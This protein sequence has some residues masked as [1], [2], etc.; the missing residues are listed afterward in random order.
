[1]M[2]PCDTFI[3]LEISIDKLIISKRHL[4]AYNKNFLI[5]LFYKIKSMS[6]LSLTNF[7]NASVTNCS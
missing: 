4:L 2:K 7:A 1:M 3:N 6:N 5:K